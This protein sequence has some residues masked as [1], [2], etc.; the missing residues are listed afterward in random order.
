MIHMIAWTELEEHYNYSSMGCG[1]DKLT[2]YSPIWF[3]NLGYLAGSKL[4][5]V[6]LPEL[7]IIPP[8]RSAD[9]PQVV[10]LPRYDTTVIAQVPLCG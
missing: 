3:E 9:I 4:A 6:H 10:Y 7:G 2:K 1:L 5:C 8:S